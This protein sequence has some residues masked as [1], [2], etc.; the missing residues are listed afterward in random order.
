MKRKIYLPILIVL[1]V[2]AVGCAG[3]QNKE[4]F[5]NTSYKSIATAGVVY[6]TSKMVARDLYAQ[7]Y[8]DEKLRVEINE[9][10]LTFQ[11]AYHSAIDVLEQYEKDAVSYGETVAAVNAVISAL[12]KI[13]GLLIPYQDQIDPGQR[14]LIFDK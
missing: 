3:P 14:A 2:L 1:M 9:V 5:L 10:A 6:N 13:A 8:I 11:E 4:E 12:G 7:N